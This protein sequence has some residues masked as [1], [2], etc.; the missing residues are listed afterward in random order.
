MAGPPIPECDHTSVGII[1]RDSS[2]RI[3]MIERAKP[4]YGY[5]PPSGHVD[6]HGSFE[7][8]ARAELLEEVG[9][10]AISLDLVVEGRISNRC[11]RR[12][13]NWHYWKIYEAQASG[14]LI[15]SPSEVRS[16]QF[17][18]LEEIEELSDNTIA[19]LPGG[20]IDPAW[21]YWFARL[22]LVSRRPYLLRDIFSF[23]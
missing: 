10:V 13:G 14:A 18:T 5:A 22:G 4:P 23:F 17:M 11:R 7:Q 9:L 20:K 8:A 21:I 16:V 19:N 2:D 12:N 6:D 15:A 3:L 1:V